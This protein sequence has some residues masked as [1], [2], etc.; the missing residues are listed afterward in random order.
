M[1]TWELL[2]QQGALQIPRANS[3]GKHSDLETKGKGNLLAFSLFS[4]IP[5]DEQMDN[6]VHLGLV[7]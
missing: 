1:L 3:L 7:A 6:V 2:W 5:G 4:A